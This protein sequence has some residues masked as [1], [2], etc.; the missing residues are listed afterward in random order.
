LSNGKG[1]LLVDQQRK[2]HS[3]QLL[4]VLVH[5]SFISFWMLEGLGC[6]LLLQGQVPRNRQKLHAPQ[7]HCHFAR[8]GS[9]IR[10]LSP[11]SLPGRYTR[12]RSSLAP[13]LQISVFYFAGVICFCYFAVVICCKSCFTRACCSAS[14]LLVCSC[15]LFI[16]CHFLFMSSCIF[17]LFFFQSQILCSQQ[18][19]LFFHRFALT[20]AAPIFQ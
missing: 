17:C 1:S 5:L 12:H 18:T 20:R 13:L 8:P 6:E 15:S 14:S 10:Y 9:V 11:V 3:S 7:R 19:I 4:V 2:Q 16:F